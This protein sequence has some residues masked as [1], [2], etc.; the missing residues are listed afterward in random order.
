[1]NFN[2]YQK[3][4]H[5][6]AQ[7]PLNIKLEEYREDELIGTR[8]LMWVYPALGLAGESGELLNKLKKVIRD[9]NG[10]IPDKLFPEI[11]NELGDLLWYIAELSGTLNCSLDNIAEDNIFKLEMRAKQNK[12]KGSGDN[13]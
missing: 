13:R 4:A 10:E 1:M 2:E 6:T 9:H 3:K 11:R 5:S 8:A 12:I 7:Y